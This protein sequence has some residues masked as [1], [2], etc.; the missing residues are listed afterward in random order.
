MLDQRLQPANEDEGERE[1]R[2]FVD[3]VDRVHAPLSTC[4]GEELQLARP[5]LYS[6]AGMAS[7]AQV[8]IRLMV[9]AD[10]YDELRKMAEARGLRLSGYVRMI[11]YQVL[12][13]A[14][15]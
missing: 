15:A 3:D 2:D 1:H 6:W 14:A 11:L 12:A 9:G 4:V 10:Q 5:A 8:E 7:A 13:R